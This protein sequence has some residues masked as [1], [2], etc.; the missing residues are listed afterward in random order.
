MKNGLFVLPK[1]A[2]VSALCAAAISASAADAKLTPDQ[3]Q[4]FEAKIRPILADHCY[5]CHSPSG[6]KIKGGLSL[7][8]RDGLLK[9]G[10]TGPALIPGNVDK[11]L[12]IRAV[13]YKEQDLQMPPSDTKWSPRS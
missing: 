6:E 3:I 1:L 7:D 11:S 5:K 9:G 12:I 10:D 4:F 2:A 13:R 8:T